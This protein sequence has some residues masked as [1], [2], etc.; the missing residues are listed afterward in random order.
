MSKPDYIEIVEEVFNKTRNK[1]TQEFKYLGKHVVRW[2][3]I[4]KVTG[5]PL[6][7]ADMINLFK[8]AVY[9]YSVRAKYAHAKIKKIDYSEA[10]RYPGVLKVI[11]AEDVPG[12][13]DVGYVLPDQPLLADRKVRYIGD[14]VALVVAESLENAREAG[15]LVNVDYEPLPVYTDVLQV[16]DLN[17]LKEKEHVLIHD[18]RGSDV[19]S[20]YKIRVGDVEKAFKE[21]SVIVEN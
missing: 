15:E 6:F 5:K 9:V 10:L 16:I 14:T 17:G 2:D 18:E 20:R 3:A 13:N 11:T 19:L 4:S 12:I 21:A 7:T 8:N 1:P